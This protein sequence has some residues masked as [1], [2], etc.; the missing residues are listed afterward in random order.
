MINRLTIHLHRSMK[1]NH[2]TSFTPS[3]VPHNAVPTWMI[4][5][6]DY[7]SRSDI[8]KAAISD[9]GDLALSHES[10]GIELGIFHP[11]DDGFNSQL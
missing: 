8:D 1:G 6:R 2:R 3:T 9:L 10:Q 11:Q 4:N 5:T 7:S